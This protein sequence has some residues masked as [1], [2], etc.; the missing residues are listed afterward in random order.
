MYSSAKHVWESHK[1]ALD[2]YFPDLNITKR[3]PE[4]VKNTTARS[5]YYVIQSLVNSALKM[6]ENAV[7]IMIF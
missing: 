1:Q 2:K 4:S 6:K 7:K 3:P 5:K